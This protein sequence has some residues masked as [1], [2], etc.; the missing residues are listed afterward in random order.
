MHAREDEVGIASCGG[1]WM[2][3][4]RGATGR[5]DMVVGRC[6][7]MRAPLRLRT[8]LLFRP[9]AALARVGMTAAG[10]AVAGGCVGA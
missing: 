4:A 2:H 5:V 10:S 6:L 3:G 7:G 1:C 9:E 8:S